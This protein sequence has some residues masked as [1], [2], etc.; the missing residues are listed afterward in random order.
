MSSPASKMLRAIVALP[1]LGIALLCLQAMDLE[2]MIAHQQPYLESGKIEWSEGSIPILSRFHYVEFL[3]EVWRGTTASFSP[4]TLGYDAVSAWQM[5]AF[6]NDLG[7]LFAVWILESSR[8][9]NKWTPAYL[10]T[11][12]AFAGQLLG[13]GSV[14]PVFYFLCFSFGPSAS[15]L[16]R[17]PSKRT[18]ALEHTAPLLPI[19]LL[20]HTSE[21]F[22]AFLASE[23][24]TRHY[25]TW[26]WQMTPLWVGIANFTITKTIGK[27]SFSDTALGSP[28]VLLGVMSLISSGVW[29]YTL[30]NCEYPLSTVFLPDASVQTDFVLHMRRALQFD[31]ICIFASS[32]LWLVYLFYDL[33]SAGL[34]GGEWVVKIAFLP[35]FAAFAGP[36]AAFALGWYWRESMLQSKLVKK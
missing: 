12:F 15:D 16:I 34:M 24:T 31:E 33:H 22:A 1:F 25:W 4:S 36:G 13:L 27:S 17:S 3:D 6:L 30:V 20:L 35:V 11:I 2:K 21:V 14:A 10:P 26:A 29:L 8:V 23:P 19:I 9:G 28:K 18:L 32:L 7:P 5:F